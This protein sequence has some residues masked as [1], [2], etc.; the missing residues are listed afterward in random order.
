MSNHLE[1]HAQGAPR[2]PR[3]L[4][5]RLDSLLHDLHAPTISPTERTKLRGHCDEIELIL[6]R[7]FGMSMDEMA[8]LESKARAER[9]YLTGKYGGYCLTG[10]AD[11]SHHWWVKDGKRVKPKFWLEDNGIGDIRAVDAERDFRRW[12]DESGY[13]E[14]S[15]LADAGVPTVSPGRGHRTPAV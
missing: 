13:A 3:H 4:I 6:L 14:A 5:R 8:L 1:E 11:G 7:F 12:M 2:A 9:A 10:D 15:W